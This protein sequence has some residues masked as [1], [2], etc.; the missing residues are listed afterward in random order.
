MTYAPLHQIRH[1]ADG[2]LWPIMQTALAAVSAWYLAVL[3][4]VEHRPAFASIAAVISLGA[5]FSE[6]RQRAVQLIGGVMLGIVVAD[7]LIRAIGNGLPQIGLLVVLAMLAA[8]LLGGTELLVTEAAVSALLVATLSSTPTVRLLDVLIGGGVALVLHT[9][10]FPPEPVAGVAR[11][12]AAVFEELGIALRDVAAALAAGDV[13]HARSAVRATENVAGQIDELRHAVVLS[14][15]TVRWSPIRRASRVEVDRYAR[16]LVHVDL[17]ARGARVLA[18]NVLV[19]ARSGRGADSE[20]AEAARELGRRRL[21]AARTVHRALAQ[22]R[23]AAHGPSQRRARHRGSREHSRHRAQ[24]DRRPAALDRGRHRA[25][26]RD[27]RDGGQRAH[28]RP[29]GRA[30][31][32]AATPHG[33]LSAFTPSDRGGESPALTPL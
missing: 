22:R 6:R 27:R 33:S 10:V 26:L 21:R 31:R 7:L 17:A 5:A 20:L 2:H 32:G 25:R 14:S 4:G 18:R 12:T 30:A 15:D 19:Y 3:L 16:I 13:I 1:R 29:D 23:R 8:V 9:L 24:R 28:R 11:S